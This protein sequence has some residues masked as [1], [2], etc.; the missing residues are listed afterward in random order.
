MDDLSEA[1]FAELLTML[2]ALE[3]VY[4]NAADNSEQTRIGEGLKRIIGEMTDEQLGRYQL[5]IEQ[6][7]LDGERTRQELRAT[8]K[9]LETERERRCR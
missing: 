6:R 3:T 8:L 5:F 9:E 2:A 7:L 1:R 4:K